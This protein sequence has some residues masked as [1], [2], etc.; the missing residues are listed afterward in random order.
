MAAQVN[1]ILKYICGF[2]GVWLV[3]HD[4]LAEWIKS[5]KIAEWTN[6]QR[7]FSGD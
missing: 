3:R 5:N 4:E 7:F 1:R 6:D 2:P